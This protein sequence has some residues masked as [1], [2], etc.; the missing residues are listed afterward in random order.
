MY[1]GKSK[2]SPAAID[3][4]KGNGQWEALELYLV[5]YLCYL[6]NFLFFIF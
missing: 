3:Q 5:C 6:K 4:I 2:S 1:D